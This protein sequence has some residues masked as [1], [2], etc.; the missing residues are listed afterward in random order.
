MIELDVVGAVI[1]SVDSGHERMVVDVVEWT[2]VT[3]GEGS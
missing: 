1:S 3:L 2:W